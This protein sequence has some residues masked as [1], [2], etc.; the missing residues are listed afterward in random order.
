MMG[1]AYAVGL[2]IG[3]GG[4]SMAQQ[5]NGQDLPPGSLATDERGFDC[6]ADKVC[7][8]RTTQLPVRLLI[9]PLSNVYAGPDPQAEVVQANVEP[10]TPWF[11]F[12][13]RDVDLT[14]AANPRGW[15]RVGRTRGDKEGW[16]RAEDAILWNNALVVTYIR[17]SP[18]LSEARSPVLMFG[19]VDAAKKMMNAQDPGAYAASLVKSAEAGER[20]KLADAGVVSMEPKRFID[21]D[22]T[23]YLLPV[24]NFQRLPLFDEREARFLQLAAAV[25]QS[26]DGEA[27]ARGKTI[28]SDEKALSEIL[29]Q[30]TGQ[31]LDVDK[32]RVEVKFVIDNTG[33]MRPYIEAVKDSIRQLQSQLKD[34]ADEIKYGL[35][36]YTDI[37]AECGD[38]CPFELAKDY[39][40]EG[41]TGAEDFIRLLNSVRVGGG[42]DYSES[43]FEGVSKAVDSNWSTDANVLRFIIVIGDASSNPFGAGKNDS[44]DAEAIRTK[45]EAKKIFIIS[46]HAKPE[47]AKVD[48]KKAEQQFK[49]IARSAE[50]AP[51]YFDVVVTPATARKEFTSAVSGVAR[52]F[53]EA[54]AAVRAG[55]VAAA[56][57]QKGEIALNADASSQAKAEAVAKRVFARALISYLGSAA[58]P[59][60]DVTAWVV[61]VDPSDVYAD[62]LEVRV[63]LE[64]RDLEDLV[65]SMETILKSFRVSRVID[66]DDFFG[67]LQA[68]MASTG[69]DQSASYGDIKTLADTPLVPKWLSALPY[70]SP[71]MELTP[72]QY[73]NMS[74]DQKAKIEQTLDRK[75]ALYKDLLQKPDIWIALSEKTTDFERVYPLPLRDLP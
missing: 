29:A 24:V 26:A 56:S 42:G 33:S 64:K 15:Y 22:V 44:V 30:P 65:K 38:G 69:L 18:V 59:P 23:P 57:I 14:D 63:L 5:T 55:S 45:A 7:R 4:V 48:W 21:Y 32:L 62:S 43:M 2:S 13:G 19:A 1:A 66:S 68:A 9:R 52:Y 61:D 40:P 72:E 73:G 11:V 31:E 37:A 41:V 47:R 70:R 28:V 46:L 49:G 50:D 3:A 53:G 35:I 36:G 6:T 58:Q 34:A 67:Q 71:L 74:K 54:T 51:A 25:P 20:G 27:R 12:A 10:F 39:V 16:V 75:L 8:D 60:R 17:P